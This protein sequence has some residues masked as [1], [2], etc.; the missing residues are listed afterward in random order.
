MCTVAGAFKGGGEG[1][2]RP[3]EQTG[4][5]FSWFSAVGRI[6]APP[7]HSFSAMSVDMPRPQACSVLRIRRCCETPRAP[8][9]GSQRD[10]GQRGAPSH[11]VGTLDVPDQSGPGSHP[12]SPPLSAS[13]PQLVPSSHGFTHLVQAHSAFFLFVRVPTSLGALDCTF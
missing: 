11:R 12:Q 10:R 4:L 9:P 2:R 7:T 6:F 13:R 1:R 3:D 8:P 5:L